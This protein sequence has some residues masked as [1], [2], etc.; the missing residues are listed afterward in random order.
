MDLSLSQTTKPGILVWPPKILY[1]T[2]FQ[3][4]CGG[5]R[6][7]HCGAPVSW[8]SLHLLQR[9]PW[10]VSSF[11]EDERPAG[12][13]ATGTYPPHCFCRCC[14]SLWPGGTGTPISSS[15]QLPRE[16][17][18]PG[19]GLHWQ[20]NCGSHPQRSYTC[21]EREEARGEVSVITACP[22]PAGRGNDWKEMGRQVAAEAHTGHAVQD[23]SSSS[24]QL[25]AQI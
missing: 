11:W 5:T 10:R 16:P 8:G 9:C 23:W 18:S 17:P 6:S 1:R 25:P 20:W 15:S 19:T 24:A 12:G 2:T 14:T 3:G 22:V 4:D 21:W 7:A 13:P